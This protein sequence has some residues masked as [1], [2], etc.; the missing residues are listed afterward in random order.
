MNIDAAPNMGGV[1]PEVQIQLKI[2]NNNDN[3]DNRNNNNNNYMYLFVSA[4]LNAR[5]FFVSENRQNW[6]QWVN[7]NINERN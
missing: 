3:S 2:V 1:G 6:L 4:I 7:N 5:I